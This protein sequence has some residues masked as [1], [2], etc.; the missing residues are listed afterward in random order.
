MQESGPVIDVKN[1]DKRMDLRRVVA[2]T[3]FWTLL[4]LSLL[5][6]IFLFP[7]TPYKLVLCLGMFWLTFI[8]FLNYRGFAQNKRIAFRMGMISQINLLI[9]ISLYC[10]YQ[11][12]F[13]DVTTLLKSWLDQ[14]GIVLSGLFP[15]YDKA[16][17]ISQGVDF[18]HLFYWLLWA[19][20]II[21]Q[22]LMTY[23]YW[24]VR[25]AK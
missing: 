14:Y 18:Y 17:W 1:S 6:L 12:Y 21:G 7:L 8:E 25:P 2:L 10:L 13:V 24:R 15:A 4:I 22:C 16:F 5:P 9:M 11:L 23:F 20:V 19:I 3:S